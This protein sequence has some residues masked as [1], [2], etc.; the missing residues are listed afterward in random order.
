MNVTPKTS[1]TVRFTFCLLICT[2]DV[3]AC[4]LPFI[5]LGFF[6]L[7]LA[8]ETECCAQCMCFNLNCWCFLLFRCICG[9]FFIHCEFFCLYMAWWCDAFT[10][11]WFFW[12]LSKK[13]CH[14]IVCWRRHSHWRWSPDVIQ[15]YMHLWWDSRARHGH[16]LSRLSQTKMCT[17]S[18]KIMKSF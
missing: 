14:K 15:S 4:F 16:Q 11:W 3:R 10:W 13:N 9:F 17:I 2:N 5:F 1:S 7:S 6:F 12:R 18:W 8:M